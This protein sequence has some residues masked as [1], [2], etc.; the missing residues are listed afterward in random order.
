MAQSA[1][2]WIRRLLW[3]SLL[4]LL[5]LFE[6]LLRRL[7][8]VRRRRIRPTSRRRSRRQTHSC[9][10]LCPYPCTSP[11][12]FR[13]RRWRLNHRNRSRLRGI[14]A[15]WLVIVETSRIRIRWRWAALP[16]R[17]NQFRRY[18]RRSLPQ[19][20]IAARPIQQPYQNLSRRPRTILAE[21][22]FICHTARNLHPRLAA[23]L[24][25]NLVQ[26]GI[27]RRNL[28][29]PIRIQHLRP[30]RT[31]RNRSNPH[32][33]RSNGSRQDCRD[34]RRQARLRTSDP[35]PQQKDNCEPAR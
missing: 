27:V 22:A 14:F 20:H 13:R 7:S 10:S 24:V 12:R 19:Q 5:Q 18:L 30:S 11:T 29:L 15:R 16:R 31:V 34:R 26:A 9:P 21:N 33:R 25:Q 28:K 17:Q 3:L 23:D 35:A 1:L 2:L 32:L 4:Q 8:R 6:D